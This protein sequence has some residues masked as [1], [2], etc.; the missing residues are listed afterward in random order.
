[1]I[2]AIVNDWTVTGLVTLQSGV[3]IAVTQSTNNN[4]FAGFGT[5]RPN[6]IGDPELPSSEQTMSRWFNTAAFAAAPQFT[7][8]TSSRNP[9]L[10]ETSRPPRVIRVFR[11]EIQPCL[12]RRFTGT[13]QC[14]T[15]GEFDPGRTR[16]H[17]RHSPGDRLGVVSDGRIDDEPRGLTNR[18]GANIFARGENIRPA[19]QQQPYAQSSSS[20]AHPS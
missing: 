7:I 19:E 3:P 5:Q 9:V 4:A 10:V 13:D 12:R 18:A 2:G 11:G 16:A 17:G 1:V 15:E 14:D 20:R 6:L 8:G